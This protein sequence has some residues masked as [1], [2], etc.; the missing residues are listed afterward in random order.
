MF[1]STVFQ[2]H[3]E[4]KSPQHAC[5][6]SLC[7]MSGDVRSTR[8]THVKALMQLCRTCGVEAAP[9]DECGQAAVLAMLQRIR[10]CEGFAAEKQAAQGEFAKYEATFGKPP[11]LG[12]WGEVQRGRELSSELSVG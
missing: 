8:R 1:G 2:L 3:R 7:N 9:R 6:K 5:L 11:P 10:G 12:G 4:L